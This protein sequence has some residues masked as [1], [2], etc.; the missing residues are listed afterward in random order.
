MIRVAAAGALVAHAAPA[1]LFLPHLRTDALAGVG[2]PGHVALTFDDGPHPRSTPH[3]LALLAKTGTRA[4]FFVLGR[5][6]AR[7]PELGREIVAAGHELA[8]HGWDHRCFLRRFPSALHDDLA[9]TVELITDVAGVRPRWLRAPYG[10]FSA[11]SLVAA[12]KL[13]L[14]PVLWTAWGFDWSARATPA[15]VA[16]T[17]HKGLRPGGTILLHDSDT[18]ASTV[19][20]WRSALGA[21]PAILVGCADR[22]LAVGP[23]REHGVGRA[24]GLLG[25]FDIGVHRDRGLSPGSGG[26]AAA[27]EYHGDR[28]G[29][30]HTATARG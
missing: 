27:A 14:R 29:G 6:L 4:T 28:E 10:V 2:D 1:A 22:G 13:G 21:L 24:R 26:P 30:Q 25:G 16:A 5:E 17:V 15:S 20:S 12:R 11:G 8:V 7:C 23:L 18:A 19:G 3:F 9:R